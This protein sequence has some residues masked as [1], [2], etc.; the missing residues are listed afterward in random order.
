MDRHTIREFWEQAWREGLWAAGWQ[1]A[2]ADLTPAEA[3]W[4]PAPQRHSI[5]QIIE[6]MLFW[7]ADALRRLTAGSGPPAPEEVARCNFPTARPL[8][9]DAW[10]DTLS[11]LA[12]TQDRVAAALASEGADISRLAYLLPHDAYHIGQVMYLRSLL[13]KPPVE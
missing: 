10:A 11:R 7:R 2:C 9:A 8:T 3:A 13:G 5:W 6:H 12:A 1:R 4:Q